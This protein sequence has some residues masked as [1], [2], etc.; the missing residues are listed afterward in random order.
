MAFVSDIDR[1]PGADKLASGKVSERHNI[2]I[3]R[4]ALIVMR[5]R[6]IIIIDLYG[7]VAHEIKFGGKRQK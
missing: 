3:A 6:L 7:I 2:A 1:G 5:S 4:I